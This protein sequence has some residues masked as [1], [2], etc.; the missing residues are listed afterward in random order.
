ME[1]EQEAEDSEEE[2]IS[3]EGGDVGDLC[4][5]KGTGCE[6]AVRDGDGEG[7]LVPHFGC[8]RTFLGVIEG[9]SCR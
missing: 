5:G 7:G 2:G 8:G 1:Q 3:R 6:G 9:R 4:F